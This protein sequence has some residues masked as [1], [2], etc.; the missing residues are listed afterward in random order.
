MPILRDFELTQEE[1]AAVGGISEPKFT[2]AD[3][4][5]VTFRNRSHSGHGKFH[6]SHMHH[7]LPVSGLLVSCICIGRMTP[8][9]AI[10]FT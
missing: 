1:V 10:A 6:I 9:V 4:V 7:G 5:E 2:S 3:S 8:L